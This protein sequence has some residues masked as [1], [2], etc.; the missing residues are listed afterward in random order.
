MRGG[1]NG[2][3]L[4]RSFIGGSS[5]PEWKDEGAENE[6]RI[7]QKVCV[8]LCVCVF[9][10]VSVWYVSVC[11]CMPVFLSVYVCMF[12][13]VKSSCS[14]CRH[15][16]GRDLDLMM[17]GLGVQQGNTMKVESLGQ[18]KAYQRSRYYDY[19]KLG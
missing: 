19:S 4:M 15:R 16:E 17:F 7:H 1:T 8:C 3:K 14:G 2:K 5:T 12:H 6:N 13:P 11:L 9:V 18:L 10:Y